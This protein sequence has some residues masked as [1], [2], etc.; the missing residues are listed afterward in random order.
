MAVGVP[1]G[2]VASGKSQRKAQPA[3]KECSSKRVRAG[4]AVHVHHHHPPL[5][6]KSLHTLPHQKAGHPSGY[7]GLGYMHLEGS[8]E[9]ASLQ[10]AFSYFRQAADAGVM[11]GQWPGH[12]DAHFFLGERIKLYQKGVVSVKEFKSI[13]LTTPPQQRG[14]RGWPW[15]PGSAFLLCLNSSSLPAG[16]EPARV[17]PMDAARITEWREA[18]FVPYHFAFCVCGMPW[19][20][21]EIHPWK[22]DGATPTTP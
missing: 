10:R 3:A 6:R 20:I 9:G 16:F 14:C 2:V 22:R 11:V 1:Q 15:N 18:V 13:V 8:V 5:G 7:F 17:S 19:S 4:L 21:Y 12:A